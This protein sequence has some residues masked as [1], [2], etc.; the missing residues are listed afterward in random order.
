MKAENAVKCIGRIVTMLHP[1]QL[2]Q[3]SVSAI[4]MTD[5]SCS[6]QQLDDWKQEFITS[7]GAC[8][9]DGPPKL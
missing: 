8:I 4:T 7:G 6:D 3:G 1:G 2:S 9:Y 5:F